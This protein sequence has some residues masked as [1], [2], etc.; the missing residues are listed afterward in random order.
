MLG[1]LLDGTGQVDIARMLV[2]FGADPAATDGILW[3]RTPPLLE[4]AQNCQL[5]IMKNLVEEL[6]QDIHMRDPA[7][8]D[9]Q[10]SIKLAPP[11]YKSLR[12]QSLIRLDKRE[13]KVSLYM[14]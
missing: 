2:A 6:R 13:D 3:H 12:R 8:R 9:V 10:K 14:I 5:E 7:C 11:D 4:T 1:A